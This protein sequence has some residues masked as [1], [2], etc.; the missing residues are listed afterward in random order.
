M[1]IKSQEYYQKKFP[2]TELVEINVL[3]PVAH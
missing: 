3:I 2:L 1:E